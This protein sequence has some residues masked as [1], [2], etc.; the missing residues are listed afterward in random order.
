MK[1]WTLWEKIILAIVVNN[2]SVLFEKFVKYC[3]ESIKTLVLNVDKDLWSEILVEQKFTKSMKMILETAISNSIAANPKFLK[4]ESVDRVIAKNELELN[5]Q[6]I[7][8]A[9]FV[10]NEFTAFPL[11]GLIDEAIKSEVSYFSRSE[12]SEF[13]ENNSLNLKSCFLDYSPV[14]VKYWQVCHLVWLNQLQQLKW[15]SGDDV[16]TTLLPDELNFDKV[17]IPAFEK[18]FKINYNTRKDP[19]TIRKEYFFKVGAYKPFFKKDQP[20]K[21]ELYVIA[22]ELKN[23]LRFGLVNEHVDIKHIQEAAKCKSFLNGRLETCYR[24]LDEV[25]QKKCDI[26]VQ[27]ELSVPFDY[28][29][30][31]CAYSERHQIGLVSEVENKRIRNVVFNFVMTVLPIKIY[32]IYND[33]IPVI[34]LKNHYAPSEKEMIH[35]FRATVPKPMPYNYH[36]FHWRGLYFTNYYCYELA[37]IKHRHIFQGEIDVLIAPVWNPD[38]NYYNGIVET[39]AR[40]IHCVFSQVNTSKYGDTRWTIPSKTEKKNPLKVKGGTTSDYPFTIALSDFEPK[41]LREFQNLAYLGQ[42]KNGSYK[43]TPP[44]YPKDKAVMRLHQESFYIDE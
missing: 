39:G 13:I 15:K 32:G 38:T 16:N 42:K 20:R 40:E 30:N 33:A 7:R 25:Q 26:A 23:K 9:G 35:G 41:K 5:Y 34:R 28:I 14:R 22:S 43:P 21:E 29:W 44:D 2:D 18:Y 4:K 24:I 10:R 8:S 6:K 11:I 17:Q 1:S 3:L 27:P 31:Y 12:I 37:N 19:H 36:L